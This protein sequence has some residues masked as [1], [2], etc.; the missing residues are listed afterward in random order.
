MKTTFELPDR[1]FREAKATAA[2]RSQS[3]RQFFTDAIAEKLNS[4]KAMQVEKPWMKHF[5]V[6]K[7]YSEELQR[8]ERVIEK[9]FET[10]HPDDWK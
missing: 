1:L 4:V 2:W 7:A 9:E 3:L 8:I 10:I 6:M 5:G